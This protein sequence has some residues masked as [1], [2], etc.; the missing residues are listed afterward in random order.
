M[1]KP[2]IVTARPT[3][4]AARLVMALVA[5]QLGACGKKPLA[6]GQEYNCTAKGGR[7]SSTDGI[8]GADE[9]FTKNLCEPL[10]CDA[11]DLA[12]NCCPGMICMPDGQC[13]VPSA[14][15]DNCERDEQ[16]Q[17]G[18][19]CLERPLMNAA[20]KTCGFPP[21][22]AKGTC[23]EGG[24]PFN[25]R[26]VTGMPC[27][28]GCGAGLVC[29]IDT[30]RCEERVS[31]R[32][33]FNDGCGQACSAGK[34][35]VYADPDLMLFDGCCEVRCACATI[36][37]VPA[38]AWGGYSDLAMSG[39]ALWLSAYNASYGDLMFAV[40]ARADMSVRRLE[41]VDGLPVSAVTAGDPKGP[42][43]GNDV[44]G[45]NVGMFTSLAIQNGEPRIAYYDADAKNLKYATYSAVDKAWTVSLIDDGRDATGADT[46]DVGRYASLA[47]DERGIAHVAYYA[48]RVAPT[49]ER[50]TS[51][52]YARATRE[53]PTGYDTW[54]R[55]LV[56][57]IRSCHGCVVGNT[58]TR[59]GDTPTC[60]PAATTPCIPACSCDEVC[61]QDPPQN[62]V[63]SSSCHTALPTTLAEP[64]PSAC[65]SGSVCVAATTQVSTCAPSR[66]DCSPACPKDQAC[67]DEVGV[68]ACRF[69]LPVANM[70][71]PP[72]GVG[73][74]TSLT[75]AKGNLP[76]LV[77]Y[78]RI[79]RHLRGAVA[80]FTSD[81]DATL[82]FA[83]GKVAC[84]PGDDV[85]AH[86]TLITTPGG[87]AVAYQ[88]LGGETL[89]ACAGT[90]LF[91]CSANAELVD[92]G[93]RPPGALRQVGAYASLAADDQG[94]LYVAYADQTNNEL[95]LS[96]Q[97]R[98]AW[99]HTVLRTEGMYGAFAKL[100]L[101]GPH[102]YVSTYR[103]EIQSF[104]GDQSRIDVERI[105]LD[106]LP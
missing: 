98:G 102:A 100:R 49:G 55:Q 32:A 95:V 101:L 56:E 39:D 7:P 59:E 87:L 37:N 11:G 89:W 51:P 28:G 82:G 12:P 36:P 19:R 85:G 38:G 75:I 93:D 91:T 47:I 54:Q 52:M 86:A 46:G 58:C 31:N 44:P 25:R 34:M 45:P 88:A 33:G 18:Q 94:L 68:P 63:P 14:R 80:R 70:I 61:I 16:C 105:E 72:S 29:N 97:R 103:R 22:D 73:L 21:V 62:G 83:V 1:Q 48:H 104:S 78:D 13:I 5:V 41:Y 67:I 66:T 10:R 24:Q 71:E 27:G 43:G 3:A 65:A 8:C 9:R 53:L 77:Y 90:D 20:S 60:L 106:E 40:L 4:M 35:L 2:S 74:F 69:A 17:P 42:R 26:C 81:G 84:T 15:L 23:P 79:R 64:C 92:E 50:V 99:Q 76:T 96:Y 57:P 6:R 30:N